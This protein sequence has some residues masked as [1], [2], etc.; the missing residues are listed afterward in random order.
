MQVPQVYRNT[1]SFISISVLYIYSCCRVHKKRE[2]LN[3]DVLGIVDS[4]TDFRCLAC[5]TRISIF[6]TESL[7][8]DCQWFCDYYCAQWLI[9]KEMAD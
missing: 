8:L 2:M 6:S 5:G 9:F 1:I 3:D 4:Y 7:S